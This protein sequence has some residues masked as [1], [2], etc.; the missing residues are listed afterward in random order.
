VSAD[1]GQVIHLPDTGNLRDAL[2]NAEA[3]EVLISQ[4]LEAYRGQLGRTPFSAHSFLT[5][6][7]TRLTELHPDNDFALGANDYEHIKAWVFEALAA[8]RLNQVRNI[9]EVAPDG[10]PTFGN[11]IELWAV[12]R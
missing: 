7:Q 6:A 12:Q 2:V 1:L 11:R 3:R 5:A 4:W 10:T 8:G 9:T